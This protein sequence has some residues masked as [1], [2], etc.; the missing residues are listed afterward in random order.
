MEIKLGV[1]LNIAIWDYFHLR[2][3]RGLKGVYGEE[4]CVY[5]CAGERGNWLKKPIYHNK[6]FSLSGKCA[7]FKFCLKKFCIHAMLKSFTEDHR[8]LTL[9]R[10]WWKFLQIILLLP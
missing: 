6:S 8:F 1:V 7:Y 4:G 3:T 5:V 2:A 9:F 10:W